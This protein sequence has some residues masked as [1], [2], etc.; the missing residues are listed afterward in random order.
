V[1]AG[2]IKEAYAV[3]VL[4]SL[5]LLTGLKYFATEVWLTCNWEMSVKGVK[6]EE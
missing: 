2:M 3:S 6:N 5:R 1:D 4:P